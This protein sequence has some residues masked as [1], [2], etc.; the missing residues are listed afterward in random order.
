MGNALFKLWGERTVGESQGPCSRIMEF[1]DEKM[2]C[3]CPICNAPDDAPGCFEC[4]RDLVNQEPHEDAK[5]NPICED[6]WW[7]GRGNEDG[8]SER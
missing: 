8:H 2:T 3:P 6:C 1:E 4:N 5:G 7:R